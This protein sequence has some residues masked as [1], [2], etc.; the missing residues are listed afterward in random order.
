M[1]ESFR[2]GGYV[3]VGRAG[4][5]NQVTNDGMKTLLNALADVKSA[6]IT[7]MFLMNNFIVPEGKSDLKG[8]TFDDI[9]PYLAYQGFTGN[10]KQENPDGSRDMRVYI[11][12]DAPF[13]M[14]SISTIPADKANQNP[15]FNAAALIMSG[16]E[17]QSSSLSSG[18]YQP[19]G[20][21]VVF[22]IALFDEQTKDNMDTFTVI[23][24]IKIE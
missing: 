12:N 21:E 5:D 3:R 4:V 7:N 22:S 23:W 11:S 16:D 6:K 19:T 17:M 2:I 8:I 14:T 24:Y 13:E 15:T 20:N 18:N 9:K 1:K 10:N